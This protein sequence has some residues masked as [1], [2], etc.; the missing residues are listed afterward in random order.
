[1]LLSRRMHRPGAEE[2]PTWGPKVGPET[3]GVRTATQFSSVQPLSDQKR[4]KANLLV[5]S[6]QEVIHSETQRLHRD[7][8]TLCQVSLP[9]LHRG[10]QAPLRQLLQR[11]GRAVLRR[12]APGTD[13]PCG[14]RPKC[15][16]RRG[17]GRTP[18]LS[19]PLSRK[20][21]QNIIIGDQEFYIRPRCVFV[22]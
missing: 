13:L 22:N 21:V 14:A 4:P 12:R 9:G 1:M 18:V 11:S 20:E 19:A 17:R 3:E 5:H 10:Q 16:G 6:I 7:V 2:S 8:P 15:R